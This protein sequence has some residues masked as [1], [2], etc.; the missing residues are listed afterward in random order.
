MKGLRAM[1]S[2]QVRSGKKALK[3]HEAVRAIAHGKEDPKHDKK[4]LG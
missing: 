2:D 4:L 1:S 3:K